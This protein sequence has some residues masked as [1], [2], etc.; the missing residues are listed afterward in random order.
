[1]TRLLVSVRSAAEAEA[2]L[3]GGA[4]LIDVKEPSRGPLGKADDRTIADVVRVAAGRRPVSASFGEL[5]DGWGWP[6]PQAAGL[7]Y[8]KWGLAGCTAGDRAAA[9]PYELEGAVQDIRCEFPDCRPV[10]AAYAD[11]R[12]AR[13]PA[14]VEVC[15]FAVRL[16]LGALLFDTW[17]KDGSTLL[18]WL[19]PPAL[20]PLIDVCRAGG[21]RVALA[22][23]LRAE[24]I[25]ALQPLQPDWFAVRGAVCQGRQRTAAVDAGKVRGLVGL[26]TDATAAN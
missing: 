25:R 15:A 22:G 23:S 21:L 20:R 5:A 18:D 13:A 1:M 10:A 9:W 8:G 3:E 2:A 11:W 7:A 24:E 6:A 12:R 19:P 4:H 17:E 14:P 26:L 16:R